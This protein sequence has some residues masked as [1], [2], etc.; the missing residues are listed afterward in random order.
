LKSRT[1]RLAKITLPSPGLWINFWSARSTDAYPTLESFFVD[2]VKILRDEVAELSRLGASYI[3]LD[4]PHYG[5]LLDPQ[6]RRFYEHQ[7]WSLDEWL[8]LG[9]DLDNAVM[10]GFA[11][12]T[13]GFHI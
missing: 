6:T 4:A 7:G 5:L 10:A 12:I 11:G 1:R 9:V 2:I 8:S 3:Q 13:F